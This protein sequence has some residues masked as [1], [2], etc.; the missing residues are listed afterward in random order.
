[1]N[2][3]RYR[4]SVLCGT[5]GIRVRDP[6]RHR[7]SQQHRR[8]MAKRMHAAKATEEERLNSAVRATRGR[9]AGKG[10]DEVERTCELRWWTRGWIR[11][12]RPRWLPTSLTLPT[13]HPDLWDSPLVLW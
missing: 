11:A 9:A 4:T 12:T 1:M 2:L 13:I 8:N 3:R 6:K 10:K 5:C 7:K